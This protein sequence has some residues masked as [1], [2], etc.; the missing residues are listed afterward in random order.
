MMVLSIEK[1][2]YLVIND[3]KGLKLLGEKLTA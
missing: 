1:T 3:M 2:L